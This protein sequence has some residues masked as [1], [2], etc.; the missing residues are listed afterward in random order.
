[1]STSQKYVQYVIS[2][3]YLRV[4]VKYMQLRMCADASYWRHRSAEHALEMRKLSFD[5][6][7]GRCSKW[8]LHTV[9][10]PT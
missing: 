8:P 4:I 5:A 6:H 7:Y 2:H 9:G 3:S 1:M 10:R